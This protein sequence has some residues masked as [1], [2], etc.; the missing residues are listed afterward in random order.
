MSS[1]PSLLDPQAWE[2]IPPIVVLISL[3][4]LG[5]SCFYNGLF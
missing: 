3:Q 5:K 4:K 1:T 2:H